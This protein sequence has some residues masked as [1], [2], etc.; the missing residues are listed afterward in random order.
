M[1]NLEKK[2]QSSLIPNTLQKEVLE[3]VRG[4]ERKI[5]IA[6]HEKYSEGWI[7]RMGGSFTQEE[8][9]DTGWH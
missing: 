3:Y 9:N 6:E 8:I 7:D 1:K 2:L 5:E 4:L